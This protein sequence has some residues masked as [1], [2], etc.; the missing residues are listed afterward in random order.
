MCPAMDKIG[1]YEA[2]YK[3]PATFANLK[4][5]GIFSFTF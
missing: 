5:Q 2:L 4:D 1:L 3:Y